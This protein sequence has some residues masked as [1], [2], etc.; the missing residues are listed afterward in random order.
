M[1]L[2]SGSKR[3]NE[4]TAEEILKLGQKQD[5]NGL[6]KI[7]N[8]NNDPNIQEEVLFQLK[9]F[10]NHKKSQKISSQLTKMLNRSLTSDEELSIKLIK[11]LGNY[12]DQISIKLLMKSLNDSNPKIKSF[13]ESSLINTGENSVENLLNDLENKDD[14]EY[15]KTISRIIIKIGE[16][17]LKYLLSRFK[18]KK[19]VTIIF[20]Q[21]YREEGDFDRAIGVMDS[22]VYND[23]K[24]IEDM[25]VNIGK[26][27]LN[28]LNKILMNNGIYGNNIQIEEKSFWYDVMQM[29]S[30][31][32]D[33]EALDIIIG[34]INDNDI[35]LQALACTALC[36]RKDPR[37]YKFLFPVLEKIMRSEDIQI[38]GNKPKLISKMGEM[39]DTRFIPPI[40]IVL[41]N[42]DKYLRLSAIYA[43]A[44]YEDSN[45]LNALINSLE[46]ID[47]EVRAAAI[48]SL[49]LIGNTISVNPIINLLNDYNSEV[50]LNAASALGRMGDR[51]TIMSLETCLK[52]EDN[53]DVKKALKMS[54]LNLSNLDELK[55]NSCGLEVNNIAKFCPNCGT[56]IIK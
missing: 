40:L 54:I 26:P 38:Y 14:E 47:S 16:P 18:I 9:K 4:V 15:K 8:K 28:P 37:T 23:L 1:G 43:L 6:L 41:N 45:A 48:T 51:K 17:S 7:L 55:C 21:K 29:I 49:S 12:T 42:N 20:I 34:Y 10:G 46:D 19:S 27:S 32:P 5:V 44:N 2:F 35:Y 24:L 13:A 36:E 56:S 31:I 52:N 30:K 39:E 53:S 3:S 25:I 11:T 33:E 22:K 50:R